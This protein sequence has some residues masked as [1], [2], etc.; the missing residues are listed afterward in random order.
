MII[1]ALMVMVFHF[2]GLISD[3]LYIVTSK[4]PT[5]GFKEIMSVFLFAPFLI[6]GILG[7][8]KCFGDDKSM[9]CSLICLPLCAPV[10]ILYLRIYEPPKDAEG[11]EMLIDYNVYFD[12]IMCLF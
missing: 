9:G 11:K 8:L 10:H 1:N 2:W 4:H 12:M 6:S 3:I 5:P 7:I